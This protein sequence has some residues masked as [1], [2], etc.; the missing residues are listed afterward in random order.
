[1]IN[2]ELKNI[3]KPTISQHIGVLIRAKILNTQKINGVVFYFFEPKFLKEK[4][5][6]FITNT[7]VIG[8][9]VVGLAI[10]KEICLNK[11][12]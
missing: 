1:M 2:K 8:A 4:M 5:D 7:V 9:G 10:A 3:S 6:K 11:L 12:D